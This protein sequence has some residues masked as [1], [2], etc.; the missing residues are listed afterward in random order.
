[1]ALFGEKYDENNVRVVNIGDGWSLECCAGTHVK[2]T[3]HVERVKIVSESAVSAGNR[4]IEAIAGNENIEN[5]LKNK[6]QEFASKLIKQIENIKNIEEHN[7]ILKLKETINHTAKNLSTI[8]EL[9][10]SLDDLSG[11]KK[12]LTFL[13]KEMQKKMKN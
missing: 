12:E 6:Q 3:A 8:E 2:N 13:M 10:R 9:E 1:M 5:Y 7:K 11:Y 4:R